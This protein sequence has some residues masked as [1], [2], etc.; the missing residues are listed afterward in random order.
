[1]LFPTFK[2]KKLCTKIIE[3]ISGWGVGIDV[4]L[5]CYVMYVILFQTF[6][7]KKNG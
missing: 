4:F 1:M 7:E 3:K 5:V 6:I 2:T